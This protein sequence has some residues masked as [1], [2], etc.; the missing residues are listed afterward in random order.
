LLSLSCKTRQ[1]K[2][3]IYFFSFSFKDNYFILF[4]SNNQESCK[5]SLAR[6]DKARAIFIFYLFSFKDN[7]FII[8]YSNS[9]ESYKAS[10]ARQDKME[11][12]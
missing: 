10:L 4:Y 12:D 6:Q 7:Y 1:S 9:Q 11:D 3:H 8:F 5:A 2:S